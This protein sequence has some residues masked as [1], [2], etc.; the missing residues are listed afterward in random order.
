M[1]SLEER[2]IVIGLVFDRPVTEVLCLG[3]HPDDIEI[4]ALGLLRRLAERHE[5]AFFR[6]VVLTGNDGRHTEAEQSMASL[7]G[8][9]ASLHM[10]NFR[11]GFL[12]YEA[13]AEAKRFV[14]SAIG[15]STP[16]VVLTP[17]E[18]D[19]HQDHAFVASL[20]Q[21]LLRDHLILEYEIPKYDGDL[22]RPQAF[23]ALTEEEAEAKVRHLEEH[24]GSQH[25]KNWYDDSGFRALMRLRG[26][27]SN[28]PSGYA[29]AFHVSKLWLE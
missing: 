1:G 17:R 16:Q 5:E 13:S 14:R 19:R 21:Q 24:F 12:P 27:E 9:R 26:I 23:V 29:E 20:A 18:D 28:S 10:G 3:A 8:E 4:G 22:G 15:D 7:F 2:R 11:D 6:F 25:E